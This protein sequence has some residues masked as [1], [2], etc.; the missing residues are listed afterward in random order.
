MRM[1]DFKPAKKHVKVSVGD[2]VRI[3][4]EFQG[5]SQPYWDA[6]VKSAPLASA[7]QFC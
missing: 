5:L 1:K 2:S 4:R 6:P 3:I 7:P